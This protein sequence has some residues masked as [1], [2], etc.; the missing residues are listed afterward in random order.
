MSVNQAHIVERVA[1]MAKVR[2]VDAMRITR[3]VL[4]LMQEALVEGDRVVLTRFGTL[5]RV[6]RTDDGP[7][8]KYVTFRPDKDLKAKI[9]APRLGE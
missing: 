7:G 9:N 4:T 8:R 1:M 3:D 6:L 2:R 5:R